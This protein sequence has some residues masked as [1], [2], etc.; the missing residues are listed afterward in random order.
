[1]NGGRHIA[2]DK[3][4]TGTSSYKR[5][6]ALIKEKPWLV[7]RALS[8]LPESDRKRLGWILSKV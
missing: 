6:E 5:I 7:I 1:M 2:R 3:G 4:T 8:T